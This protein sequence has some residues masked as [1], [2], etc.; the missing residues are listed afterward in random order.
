[1]LCNDGY[2]KPAYPLKHKSL[3]TM[4][5]KIYKDWIV[6][7]KQR[8]ETKQHQLRTAFSKSW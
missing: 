7:F 5:Q 6:L 1:M 2:G 4:I 3:I 8:S